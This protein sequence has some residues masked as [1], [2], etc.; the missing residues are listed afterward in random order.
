MSRRTQVVLVG[1]IVMLVVIE[2]VVRVAQPSRT[3][4]QIINGGDNPIENL[5]VAYAGSRVGVGTLPAGESTQVRLSGRKKGI[6][7]SNSPRR[8][9]RWRASRSPISTP[10]HAP[11]WLETGLTIMPNQVTKYMDD[12]SDTSPLGTTSA[13]GSAIGSLPSSIRPDDRS[14]LNA[15]GLLFMPKTTRTFVAIVIPGPQG[16][17]LTRLQQQLAP[18]IPA[19]RF[20][21]SPPFHLT[22]AFLGES[23][24]ARPERRLPGRGRSRAAICRVWT[25]AR[26]PRTSP[27][28]AGRG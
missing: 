22:L 3:Y 15:S 24:N 28:R 18:T 8:V 25:S 12:A 2:I 17:K 20:S 5:V 6:S 27:A 13:A 9:I 10:T 19:A 11:G 16:E 21:T 7:R 26:R 4:I 14:G 1:L 23:R